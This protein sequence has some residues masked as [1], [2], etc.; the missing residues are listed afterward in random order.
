MRKGGRR[1][2]GREGE[3][4]IELAGAEVVSMSVAKKGKIVFKVQLF[5]FAAPHLI[6]L[7]LK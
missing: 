6:H 5:L 7:Y 1:K 3:N 2:G 4:L